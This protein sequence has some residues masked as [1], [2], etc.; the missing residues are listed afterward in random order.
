MLLGLSWCLTGWLYWRTREGLTAGW[1]VDEKLKVWRDRRTGTT[2]CP[3]CAAE[4]RVPL[5]AFDGGLHCCQV[6]DKQFMDYV[7]PPGA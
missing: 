5:L 1:V 3:V 6:C 4:K 7:T 2:Y